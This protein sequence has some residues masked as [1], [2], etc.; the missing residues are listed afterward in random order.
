MTEALA[1]IIFDKT[2]VYI[3]CISENCYKLKSTFTYLC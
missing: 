3:I 2:W 1:A